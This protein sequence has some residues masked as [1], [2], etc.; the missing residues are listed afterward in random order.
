VPWLCRFHQVHHSAQCLDWLAASRLHLVDIVATRAV[1][2]VPV[3]PAR[4]G[5]EGD[6]VPESYLCQLVYPFRPSALPSI[7]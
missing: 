4:Y 6:P 7:K 1:G 3:W 5:L 2:F